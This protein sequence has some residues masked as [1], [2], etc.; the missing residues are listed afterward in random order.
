MSSRN[1]EYAQ[2]QHFN[3]DFFLTLSHLEK[4]HFWFESRNKIIAD[5]FRQ[6]VQPNASVIEIGA[7]TCSVAIMLQNLG[8]DVTVS[9]VHEEI[10]QFAKQ[11]NI[12]RALCFDLTNNPPINEC[13][14]VVG[15]FDV[16]EHIADD[17][18]A[19][20]NAA[21]L[22]RYHGKI[23]I[24]VPAHKW[25]WNKSDEEASHKRRYTLREIETLIIAA[26][27]RV[28]SV[29]Y[30]FSSLVP[31]LLFRKF[32]YKK[33]RNQNSNNQTEVW[34]LRPHPVLNTA[35]MRMLTA[36]RTLQKK[37][38]FPFGGSIVLVAEKI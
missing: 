8:Y 30:F 36:E 27:L 22:L 14:N 10:F 38:S 2:C 33:T 18:G 34:G 28:V 29:R 23:I 19:I 7:G 12:Q 1:D 11:Q 16:L 32:V 37:I 31:F 6:Y 21:R 15:L 35:L 5:L 9:D 3:A 26:G 25:L 24:T 20:K 13:F 4:G 17:A